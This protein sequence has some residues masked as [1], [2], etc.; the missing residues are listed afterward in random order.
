MFFKTVRWIGVIALLICLA[1]DI[2][3]ARIFDQI[4][5]H[6]NN[7]VVTLGAREP[8]QT[9]GG[10]TTA[11]APVQFARSDGKGES[12]AGRIAGPF[13]PPITPS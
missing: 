6:V 12:G 9:T 13:Y 2:T 3:T 1:G 11:G 10:R 4:I 5:A 8:H 7:E